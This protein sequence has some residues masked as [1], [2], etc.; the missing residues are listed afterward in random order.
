M[1]GR[2]WVGETLR[3]YLFKVCSLLKYSTATTNHPKWRSARQNTSCSAKQPTFAAGPCGGEAAHVVKPPSTF[4]LAP[5][6]Y[7]ESESARKLTAEATSL[8]RP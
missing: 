4:Q 7:A 5:V 2:N 6:T 8:A 1:T 3:D